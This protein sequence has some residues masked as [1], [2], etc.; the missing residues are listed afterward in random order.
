MFKQTYN[1]PSLII[2]I[3]LILFLFLYIL[4]YRNLHSKFIPSTYT[5][6][7]LNNNNVI[8]HTSTNTLTSTL[9]SSQ[10]NTFQK[11]SLLNDNDIV[12]NNENKDLSNL[13]SSYS[14]LIKCYNQSQC[15]QP[16]LQ[17]QTFIYKVYYCTINNHD[18]FYFT[19]REGLL[20]HPNIHLVD[21]PE[22]AD[23]LVYLPCGSLW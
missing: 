6:E 21:K 14:D 11:R 17:L 16:I 4:K 15:I 23:F 8:Q 20:S 3:T 2:L 19:I 1:R 5:R 7:V 12:N 10:Y 9:L 18:R 13:S 22:S